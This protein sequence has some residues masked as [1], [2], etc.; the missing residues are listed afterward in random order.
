MYC[1]AMNGLINVNDGLRKI[2]KNRGLCEEL[3]HRS[4]ENVERNRI[5]TEYLVFELKFKYLTSE[6][7]RENPL[8]SEV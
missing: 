7:R 2:K 1:T 4:P 8:K 5:F 3:Y 6:T